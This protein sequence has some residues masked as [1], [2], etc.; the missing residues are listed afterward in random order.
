MIYIKIDIIKKIM[1]VNRLN[2]A[3]LAK[4]IGVD[5][6]VIT[7]IIRGDRETV[8][9]TVVCGLLKYTG[10]DFDDIFFIYTGDDFIQDKIKSKLKSRRI[11]ISA[12]APEMPQD[13]SLGIGIGN[14]TSEEKRA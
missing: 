14:N 13:E 12:N 3:Q 5:P 9:T 4:S 7:R 8:G 10:L 1:E 6:A 2:Q 11:K